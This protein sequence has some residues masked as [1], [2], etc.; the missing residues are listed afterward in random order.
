MNFTEVIAL[1]QS[2]RLPAPPA[3]HSHQKPSF[4]IKANIVNSAAARAFQS[5]LKTL[6]KQISDW[7]T[8]GHSI[9]GWTKRSKNFTGRL[10]HI[11][12]VKNRHC[13][14]ERNWL[15][16][17]PQTPQR[18]ETSPRFLLPPLQPV[19]SLIPLSVQ[20]ANLFS[21]SFTPRME[22]RKFQ[23]GSLSF[24]KNH[25]GSSRKRG[26][27][28]GAGCGEQ[29]SSFFRNCYLYPTPVGLQQV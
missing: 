8:S 28:S 16:V 19:A 7:V 20:T 26:W 2:S 9:R 23:S 10:R 4:L 17:L 13:S 24:V 11:G 1:R 12:S 3:F 29:W 5:P 6:P 15:Q 21:F 27:V 22:H 14:K 25:K 18:M